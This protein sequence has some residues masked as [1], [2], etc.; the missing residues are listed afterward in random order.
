MRLAQLQA[1]ALRSALRGEGLL[2]RTGPV[3]VRIRSQ[4]DSVA[5]ALA[6]LYADQTLGTAE[7]FCDFDTRIDAVDGLRHWLRP[8]AQFSFEGIRPFKPM[9]LPHA[10]AML[11]WGLN[12]CVSGH[13]HQYIIIHA[14][15][16]ERG[17]RAMVLPAP[18]G[19]G[20][21]TLCAGLVNRGWRLLSDELTLIDPQTGELVP[22]A[23]PVSLK[24]RSIE[25][26]KAFAPQAVFGPLTRDTVKGTVAHMKPPADS[27][28]RNTERARLAWVVFPRYVAGS[29][30]TPKPLPR[31]EAMMAL[32]DNAFNYHLHGRQGFETLVDRVAASHCLRFEYCDLEQACQFFT[33]LADA[34]EVSP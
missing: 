33:Q 15:V 34:A 21:S 18:P 20:K 13:C 22:L 30:V 19:S 10:S 27:V 26:I 28:L 8:Q 25:V 31:A 6:T 12:W 7:E 23:R 14:A 2:I 24:N 1:A 11:E 29:P 32:V 3:L 5:D 17:G 4:L 9:A 16:V